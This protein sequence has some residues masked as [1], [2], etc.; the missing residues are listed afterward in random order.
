[1]LVRFTGADGFSSSNSLDQAVESKELNLPAI[2]MADE[3]WARIGGDHHEVMFG[4]RAREDQQ[5]GRVEIAS[6]PF[7]FDGHRGLTSGQPDE[8][9]LVAL[10]VAPVA[11]KSGLP[12][13]T[14]M[15][16]SITKRKTNGFCALAECAS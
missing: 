2:V 1:M 8:V 5:A 6:R 9:N 7:A 3:A 14:R 12:Y 16:F 10:L 15:V 4:V 11:R 13:D